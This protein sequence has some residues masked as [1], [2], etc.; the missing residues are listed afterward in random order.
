MSQKQFFLIFFFKC[1]WNQ[2]RSIFFKFHINVFTYVSYLERL[3][4]LPFCFRTW[5]ELVIFK[6]VPHCSLHQGNAA[7]PRTWKWNSQPCSKLTV[8]FKEE[9]QAFTRTAQFRFWTVKHVQNSCKELTCSSTP[10][11]LSGNTKQHLESIRGEERRHSVE[12][13]LSVLEE[14]SAWT[15]HYLLLREKCVGIWKDATPVLRSAAQKQN[16]ACMQQCA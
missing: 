11:L 3:H 8:A 9:K 4:I 1:I 2:K 12:K 16:P 14:A 6:P 13:Y 15:Q 7:S 5:E 10:K